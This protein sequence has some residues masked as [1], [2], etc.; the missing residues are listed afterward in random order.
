MRGVFAT[1]SPQCSFRVISALGSRGFDRQHERRSRVIAVVSAAVLRTLANGRAPVVSAG[2]GRH[3]CSARG[4]QARVGSDTTITDYGVYRIEKRSRVRRDRPGGE[5]GSATP[6]SSAG[7][8]PRSRPGSERPPAISVCCHRPGAVDV[9]AARVVRL[10]EQRPP[11]AA[12]ARRAPV[13]GSAAPNRLRRRSRPLAAGSRGGSPSKSNGQPEQ[14]FS[15]AAG[16][17]SSTASLEA[18]LAVWGDV[19]AP[20]ACSYPG[21]TGDRGASSTVRGRRPVGRSARRRRSRT[22]RARSD[23]VEIRDED[24][25]PF[26]QRACEHLAERAQ[27]TLPPLQTTASGSFTGSG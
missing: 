1:S 5:W 4:S 3:A 8:A 2:R 20:W 10:D 18:A 13:S 6:R 22:S 21:R 14:E 25:L 17:D 26:G 9:G 12:R 23:L 7:A 11:R 16:P 15:C 24:S 27:Y 19:G